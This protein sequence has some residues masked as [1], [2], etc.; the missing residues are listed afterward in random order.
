MTKQLPAS[1]N[2]TVRW[3]PVIVSC[4]GEDP[5]LRISAFF[6]RRGFFFS[7]FKYKIPK[8]FISDF[9]KS[10]KITFCLK[11]KKPKKLYETFT[12]AK[13]LREEKNISQF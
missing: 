7:F 3:Y 4:G 11:R 5:K 2:Q 12:K 10:D 6:M 8:K 1:K 9:L 13:K